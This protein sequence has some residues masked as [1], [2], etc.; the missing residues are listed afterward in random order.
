MRNA[1]GG[2]TRSAM[3]DYLDES[4]G[5][6]ARIAETRVP[7]PLEFGE[8]LHRAVALRVTCAGNVAK[9]QHRG[10][11]GGGVVASF[12]SEGNECQSER[13]RHRTW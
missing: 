13:A 1:T 9:G 7:F 2:R 11:S 10:G 3:T 6:R 4:L 12:V 8:D 5:E